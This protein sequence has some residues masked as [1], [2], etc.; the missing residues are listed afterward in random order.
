VYKNSGQPT[1]KGTNLAVP[2]KPIMV[3]KYRSDGTLNK[4]TL[5]ETLNQAFYTALV[6]NVDRS[7][8]W[9][10][11]PKFVNAEISKAESVYETNNDGSKTFVS[12]G[13]RSFTAKFPTMQPQYISVLKSGNCNEM[14]VYF[15]DKNG[16]LQGMS[17]GTENELYP[18]DLNANTFNAIL[19]WATDT[20]ATS[21]DFSFE[22]ATDMLDENIRIITSGDMVSVNLLNLEGLYDAKKTVVSTGQTSTV[23]KLYADSLNQAKKVA[24]T[25]LTATD[26]AIYNVT[27]SAAVTILTAT[28]T[29]GVAGEYT[30][31]YA[32][33]TIADV[34]RITPTKVGIDFTDVI[35]VTQIVA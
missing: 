26:F 13:V 35:A 7:Q 24:I 6:N 27:D 16:S 18:F 20:T 19:N 14:A 4:I 31:T 29:V 15:V 9:Y 5:P 10:P 33:Q 23:F 2:R 8:R 11:L 22:F 12:E 3:P 34:L 1:C 21:V 17:N 25:G 28:E 32:S 30:L